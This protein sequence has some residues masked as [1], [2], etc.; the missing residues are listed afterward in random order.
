MAKNYNWVALVILAIFFF[1][2][3]IAP[4]YIG[5]YGYNAP[6]ETN[7]MNGIDD[8][9]NGK[10]DCADPGCNGKTCGTM[11]CA[12]GNTCTKTCSNSVCMACC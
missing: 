4:Y 5:A 9:S 7:C 1:A 6:S 10:T 2:A 3:V 11:N 8:N 12:S